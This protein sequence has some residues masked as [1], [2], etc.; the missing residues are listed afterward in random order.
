MCHDESTARLDASVSSL[1]PTDRLNQ[2]VLLRVIFE[3]LALRDSNLIGT[4]DD[5]LITLADYLK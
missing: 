5:F 4:V 3:M 1:V 2:V